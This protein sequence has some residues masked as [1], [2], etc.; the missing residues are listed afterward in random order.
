LC[1][2]TFHA[3]LL[4]ALCL[5]HHALC[6]LF[7]LGTVPFRQVCARCESEC[8]RAGSRL[9]LERDGGE[10]G[11]E[12]LREYPAELR[13]MY[14]MGF[15]V[16]FPARVPQV[17]TDAAFKP[18]L[19]ASSSTHSL[20]RTSSSWLQRRA[21]SGARHRY[22]NTWHSTLVRHRGRCCHSDFIIL[23]VRSNALL[24]HIPLGPL[25]RGAFI[26]SIG[27]PESSACWSHRVVAC[28]S[29]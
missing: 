28:W 14:T 29:H 2:G 13:S 9:S 22:Y 3:A 5:H 6:D 25:A 15:C 8:G 20:S 24:V 18:L 11:K 7:L 23:A 26:G 12:R 10:G 27:F 1:L 4:P 16:Y 21:N 17:R 19:L